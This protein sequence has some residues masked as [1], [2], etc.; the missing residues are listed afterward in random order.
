MAGDNVAPDGATVPEILARLRQHRVAPVS[1]DVEGLGTVY[2][3]KPSGAD[4]VRIQQLFAT[5]RSGGGKSVPHYLI[6]PLLWCDADGTKLFPNYEAGVAE[7]DQIDGAIL[8]PLADACMRVTG[9]G[10]LLRRGTETAEKN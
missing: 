8:G 9:V 10:D 3:R 5:V 2:F 1:A 6:V 7:L 4:W